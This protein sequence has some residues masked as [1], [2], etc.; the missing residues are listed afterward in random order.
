MLA[1]GSETIREK[2]R[3]A[4]LK[5]SH[6]AHL[7]NITVR[8]FLVSTPNHEPS[9]YSHIT[10]ALCHELIFTSKTDSEEIASYC[11]KKFKVKNIS[12]TPNQS[13]AL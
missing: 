3:Y 6:E 9:P 1:D 11:R 12:T 8:K 4:I 5:T 10:L 13:K 2:D 7:G